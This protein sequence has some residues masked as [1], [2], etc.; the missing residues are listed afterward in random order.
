VLAN[1]R[2]VDPQEA[3]LGVDLDDADGGVLVG[4]VPALLLLAQLLALA[5]D[6][7]RHALALGDVLDAVD[8]ADDTTL[9]I[10]QRLDVEQHHDPGAVRPL[11]HDLGVADRLARL[12]HASHRGL[13]QDLAIGVVEPRRG[14]ELLVGF[15]G[16]GFAA[17]DFRRAPV[18]LDD[19]RLGIAD[20]GR[21]RQKLE[22]PAGFGHRAIERSDK[23]RRLGLGHIAAH[24]VPDGFLSAGKDS[25]AGHFMP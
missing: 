19:P 15:A 11:D 21:H 8:R 13:L 18:V 17:P 10:A 9:S 6:L 4:R 22:D 5:L 1:S 12:Q 23:R 7:H 2:L 16:R 14:G 25:H 3:A 20:P 24:A